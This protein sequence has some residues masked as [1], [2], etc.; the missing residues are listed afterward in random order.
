MLLR[1][2]F[3]LAVHPY[4]VNQHIKYLKC[5]LQG[6]WRSAVT[7]YTDKCSLGQSLCLAGCFKLYHAATTS[8][9]FI[10]PVSHSSPAEFPG[11]GRSS[12]QGHTTSPLRGIEPSCTTLSPCSKL[13]SAATGSPSLGSRPATVKSRKIFKRLFNRGHLGDWLEKGWAASSK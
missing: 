9:F 4:L 13:E 6:N 2:F 7:F 12:W 3:F 10:L 8:V 11:G 1:L 5:V